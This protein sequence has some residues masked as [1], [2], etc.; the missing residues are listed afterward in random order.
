MARVVLASVAP[1]LQGSPLT[2]LAPTVDGDAVQQGSA[3]IVQ[4][5]SGGALNVTVVT[6]G[7]VGG[8]LAV[9]DIVISIPA[10]STRVLGPFTDSY[11]PQPTGPTAG[12]VDVDYQTPT[13]FLRAAIAF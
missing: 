3:L 6:G 13:S 1:S 7:V 8:A 10:G 5:T 12:R 4:N 9:D 11:L 2:M